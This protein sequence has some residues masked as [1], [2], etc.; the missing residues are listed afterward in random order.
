MLLC[1]R[2]LFISAD[3]IESADIIG[4]RCYNLDR[5]TATY[6]RRR[7]ARLV[8]AGPRYHTLVTLYC[9]EL[10]EYIIEFRRS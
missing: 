4:C 2:S 10:G 7:L 9:Q 6:R 3:V 8:S 5:P 1:G